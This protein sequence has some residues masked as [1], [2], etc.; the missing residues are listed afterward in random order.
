MENSNVKNGPNFNDTISP[1]K[2]ASGAVFYCRCW[3]L[4]SDKCVCIKPSGKEPVI[5]SLL[6]KLFIS[7]KFIFSSD[8]SAATNQL[9]DH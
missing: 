2:W 5:A 7:I 6:D 8:Q 3:L 4:L 9:F 1:K